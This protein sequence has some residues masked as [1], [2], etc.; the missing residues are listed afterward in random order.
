MPRIVH[1]DITADDPKRAAKFY[2]EVFGWR[3][4][5]WEGPM[6]YWLITTGPEEEPGINGGLSSRERMSRKAFV[7]TVDVPDL[8]EYMAKVEEMGGKVASPKMPITGV[9][10]MAVC[11]D[12]EGNTFNIMEA[13]E[14]AAVQK[15]RP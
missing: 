1:F 7:N 2:T 11:E 10:Y 14:S 5:K 6:D 4:E 8:D 3:I 9:G 13:D 12:T 15:P